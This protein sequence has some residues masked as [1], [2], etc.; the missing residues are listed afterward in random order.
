MAK[1]MLKLRSSKPTGNRGKNASR[2]LHYIATREGAVKNSAYIAYIA[3]R[4]GAV[5]ND[6]QSFGL[7]GKYKQ[8][9]GAVRSLKDAMQ[10]VKEKSE[11]GTHIYKAILSV[12][13]KDAL[14]LG[15]DTR[16]GWN[17]MIRR[18][19]HIIAKEMDIKIENFEWLASV[20]MEKGHPHLHLDFWDKNQGIRNYFIPPEKANRLRESLTRA[21]FKKE[22]TPLFESRK[23]AKDLLK[24]ETLDILGRVEAGVQICQG[25][26]KQESRERILHL[27]GVQ[28]HFPKLEKQMC[29]LLAILPKQGSLK[30]QYMSPDVKE[31]LRAITKDLIANNLQCQSA[32]DTYLSANE[33]IS[34]MYSSQSE[35]LNNAREKAK[36]YAYK[37]ID[38]KILDLL[39]PVLKECQTEKKNQKEQWTDSKESSEQDLS[40]ALHQGALTRMNYICASAERDRKLLKTEISKQAKREYALKHQST[41]GIDWEEE[42]R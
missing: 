21:F 18:H 35:R 28:R 34:C 26:S 5:A 19:M 12:Q 42:S 9:N 22:I 8:I 23:Q 29:E 20:H 33:D 11:E 16:K 2:H 25:K 31:K 39:R 24:D 4:E 30:Q 32:M 38:N 41:S 15:L 6:N 37:E 7:F 3:K 1:L 17:D 13:E 27:R 40:Y 36:E 10:Y 14:A